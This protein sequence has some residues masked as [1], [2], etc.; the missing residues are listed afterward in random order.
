MMRRYIDRSRI[1]PAS[2][3]GHEFG[4]EPL[5]C[6]FCGCPASGLYM[7]PLPHVICVECGADGPLPPDHMTRGDKGD[8]CRHVVHLWN[9]RVPL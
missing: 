2:Q 8:Q 6:P 5:P 9:R 1:M 4:V 3:V 7:G